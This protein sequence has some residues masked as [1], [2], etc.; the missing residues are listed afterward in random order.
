MVQTTLAVCTRFGTFYLEVS[1]NISQVHLSMKSYE[2]EARFVCLVIE[3]RSLLLGILL[4]F[5]SPKSVHGFGFFKASKKDDKDEDSDDEEEASEEDEDEED[6]VNS[7]YL[8]GGLGLHGCMVA[9]SK[10]I[11]GN[12][13]SS[14]I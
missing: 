9:S 13:L 1:T 12:D 6:E 5:E 14:Y 11:G 7:G 2:A 10:V 3:I 8:V 4:L